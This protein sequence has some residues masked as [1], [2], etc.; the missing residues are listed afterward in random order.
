MQVANVCILGGTGFVGRA[1]SDHLTAMGTGVRVVTR[2]EVRA[3][4]L[5]VLPTVEVMEG[6][7]HDPQS[8]RRCFENMDVVVNLVGILHETRRQTFKSCHVE[9]PARVV[10]ACRASGVQQLIHMSALG[11]SA[12]GPSAYLRSKAAGEAAVRQGAGILPYT[13]FRPSVIFGEGDRFLNLFA[14]LLRLMPVMPLAGANARFQPVWVEDVARAVAAAVG[15]RHAF[16]QLYELAGPRV[17]TLAELVQFVART[18]G[19]RRKV[20][21]LPGTLARM[22]AF[23][24]EHLPGKLMTRDNLLSMSVD[25]VSSQPFPGIFGF[26]PAPLEAVVPEYMHASSARGR[27]SHYRGHAGR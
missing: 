12:E 25:N 20:L 8:L 24:F 15:N 1:I 21:P 10:E 19:L 23:A 5:G 17:Y 6:D 18:R 7:V 26:K 22:Q 4:D 9:L 2:R 14:T 16:G 3:R 13:I 27:Y 11:A